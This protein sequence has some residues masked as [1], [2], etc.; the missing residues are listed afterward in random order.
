VEQPDAVTR[1]LQGYADEWHALANLSDEQAAQQIR[2]HG[3]DIL[4]DLVGH[5]AKNRL[6]V[7][8]RRA[9][10]VQVAHFGYP[11]TTGLPTM[12][13]RLTDTHADP[14]G[15]TEAYYTEE[16]VRLPEVAWCY[17][18]PPSPDVSRLPALEAGLVTFGSF[19]K[20]AKITTETLGLWSRIM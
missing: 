20:L 9:A 17:Q 13:Y 2:S 18:P 1:R 4:V 11:N 8:A 16:L 10:P 15:L 3:I 12:D 14:P 6:L 7:F 19:N 5:T